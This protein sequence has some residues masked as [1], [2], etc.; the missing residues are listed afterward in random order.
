MIPKPSNK[1]YIDRFRKFKS[2]CYNPRATE[3]I[4]GIIFI[5]CLVLYQFIFLY[6]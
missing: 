4:T 6:T 3:N 1:F 2:F 5:V